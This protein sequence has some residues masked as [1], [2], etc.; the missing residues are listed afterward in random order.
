MAKE[1]NN[2]TMD[3]EK[4]H[5]LF[6]VDTGLSRDCDLPL[7]IE[8]AKQSLEK[9]LPFANKTFRELLPERTELKAADVTQEE[10][11]NNGL[12]LG[13]YVRACRAAIEHVL[14]VCKPGGIRVRE[15]RACLSTKTKE[16]NDGY[17]VDMCWNEREGWKIEDLFTNT[18]IARDFDRGPRLEQKTTESLKELVPV[19]EKGLTDL[20]EE[21]DEIEER[22]NAFGEIDRNWDRLYWVE[23]PTKFFVIEV[24][25]EGQ[26]SFAPPEVVS[27]VERF[28][29]TGTAL[30]QYFLMCCKVI[31]HV[32]NV[33]GRDKINVEKLYI[34]VSD[35]QIY[36]EQ[37]YWYIETPPLPSSDL[38]F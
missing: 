16:E 28:A 2:G 1:R 21:L 7:R 36:W 19:V 33:C 8:K 14:N 32:L 30:D 31:E 29:D 27:L 26:P 37:D 18:G 24:D 4:R 38:P 23:K 35:T 15:F 22:V 17:Y 5:K 6:A 34:D 3:A 11:V 13:G 12:F 25:E 20:L 10:Y 9:L